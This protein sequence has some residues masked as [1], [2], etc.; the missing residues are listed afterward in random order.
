MGI[1]EKYAL[2]TDILIEVARNR[3]FVSAPSFKW[4]GWPTQGYLY[5][6][7]PH[8]HLVGTPSSSVFFISKSSMAIVFTP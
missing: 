2:D 1:V 5:A 8:L 7:L 6:L 4:V 3:V